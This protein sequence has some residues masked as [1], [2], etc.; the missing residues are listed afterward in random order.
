MPPSVAQHETDATAPDASEPIEELALYLPEQS[1]ID[2]H[3]ALMMFLASFVYLYLFRRYTAMDPDEGIILQGAERI[4]NGQVLYRDFFSFFTPGSYYLLALLFRIFGSSM[5]VARSALVFLGSILSVLTYLLARRVVSRWVALATAALVTLTCL[6]YRFLVLHNWDSTG[7]ACLALYSAV[8]FLEGAAGRET[9]KWALAM[10]SFAALTV[11]FEQSK[12]AGLVLGL[13]FGIL[14]VAMAGRRRE[15]LLGWRGWIAVATGFAWPFLLTFGYFAAQHSLAPMLAGWVWPLHHY[16]RANR[17][18]Y[19]YQNWSDSS[20]AILFGSHSCSHTLVAVLVV[21]P[22][23]LVPVLPLVAVGILISS[24]AKLLFCASSA[25]ARAAAL[26]RNGSDALLAERTFTHDPSRGGRGGTARRWVRV[27]KGLTLR[28]FASPNT[29]TF[30]VSDRKAYYILVSATL[31]GLLLSVVAGRA[32]ILHFVY[33]APLF[34][35]VLAWILD[36]R[37]V[38]S[39]FFKAILPALRVLVLT[40]FGFLGLTMLVKNRGANVGVETRRG[41]INTAVPDS[42]LE[43]VQAHVNPGSRILVYPY[44]PLYYYLTGTFSPTRYEYIQPGMHTPE[45]T[46]EVERELARDRTPVVLYEYS[47]AEKIPRSWPNTPVQFVARDPVAAF[48]LGHYRSCRTLNSAAG[49]EF[50]FMVR[51]DLKCPSSEPRR[52][53]SK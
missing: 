11:L 52:T 4:L 25:T 14:L 49:W 27:L 46:A 38:G 10:G 37:N 1:P 53:A 23:F 15:L 50:L 29:H 9:R 41:A 43:Y 30:T 6:P 36:G 28:A 22:C 5:L 26:Q 2:R 47:F 16:S 12:G 3:L 48:V 33:L 44:L 8:R 51:K 13:T 19:G 7:W 32:D 39:S 24:S 45:Q 20:R 35:L 17:V 34:Y 21:A 42:I 40:C 31:S 18:P